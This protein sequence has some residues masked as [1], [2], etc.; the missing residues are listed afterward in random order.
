VR[1]YVL[2]I[3]VLL[4]IAAVGS[5]H[6]QAAQTPPTQTDAPD[7]FILVRG[8]G[9]EGAVVRADSASYRTSSGV[10]PWIELGGAP[11]T[12]AATDIALAERVLTEFIDAAPSDT[13]SKLSPLTEMAA[14]LRTLKRQYFGFTSGTSRGVWVH[15]FPVAPGD[16]AADQ[17][18]RQVVVMTGG[19]CSNSWWLVDLD[20]MRLLRWACGGAR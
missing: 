6:I 18:Q 20:A 16:A 9:Y 10:R 13:P 4:L 3:A 12:P 14:T 11:W 8:T 17:W 1:R 19:R 15:V 2:S 5:L 7:D